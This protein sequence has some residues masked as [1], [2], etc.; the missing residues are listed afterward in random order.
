[1]KSDPDWLR[2]VAEKM[3]L[4]VSCGKIAHPSR[5]SAV[6][7]I[8]KLLSRDPDPFATLRAYYCADCRRWHVGHSR[9]D[10][11]LAQR[12]AGGAT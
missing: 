9:K 1:M 6:E 10:M 2:H 5:A 7:A 4:E 12:L 3:G 8:G 11:R